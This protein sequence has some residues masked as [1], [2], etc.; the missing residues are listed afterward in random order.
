MSV[1]LSVLLDTRKHT[2]F[3]VV[4]FLAV[5]VGLMAGI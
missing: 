5:H 1:Y 3:E 4:I 2:I